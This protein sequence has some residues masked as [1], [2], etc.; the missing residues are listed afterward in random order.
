MTDVA[1]I[2]GGLGLIGAAIARTLIEDNR[3]ERVVCLDHYGRYTSSSEPDFVDYRKHR[4]EGIR[5]RVD[6]ERAEARYALTVAD[7]LDRYR[8]RLLFHLASLPLAK[9]DNLSAEE[10][11]DGS[12]RSTA[13][14]LQACAMLRQ[15][16][17][18]VPERFVYASSS[19]VYGH[20]QYQ[21]ADEAHPTQ[22]IGIYGTVKLAGEVLTR[23]LGQQYQLACT[24]VRP[25]AVY[26]PTDM[27]RRVSQIFLDAAIAGRPLIIEGADEAI[28]FTYV[29]D[30]ARGFV[31][32]ALA[33]AAAGET[34]NITAGR[35]HTLLEYANELR[36]HFP[37]LRIELRERDATRPRRGTLAIDKARRLLSYEPRVG[38]AEGVDRT[39]AFARQYHP[40]LAGRSA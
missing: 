26:G 9:M 34:F 31:L 16:G 5:D 3:V 4:L 33:P 11:I 38:L 18:A 22:P 20:F 6:V 7:L 37:D 32:A 13:N 17:A 8:P 19:M 29:D 27:N 2:T 28:D 10:A 15:R 36:R 14:L 21:P 24:I 23:G 1:M 25:S 39:V 35:A 40:G 12:V 30:V